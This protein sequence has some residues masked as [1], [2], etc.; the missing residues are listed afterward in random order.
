[1]IKK[2]KRLI[3]IY[4]SKKMWR[5]IK[6]RQREIRQQNYNKTMIL[7]MRYIQRQELETTGL[8]PTLKEQS[9]KAFEFFNNLKSVGLIDK[10]NKPLESIKSTLRGYDE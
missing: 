4:Q 3:V 2:I 1:M 5:E 8:L 10:C 9:E 6:E 7:L